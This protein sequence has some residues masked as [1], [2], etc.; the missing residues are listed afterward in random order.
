[1]TDDDRRIVVVGAGIGGLVL[2]RGLSK[3][4]SSVIVVEAAP[5]LRALG[6]G[7][8]L[9]ANAMRILDELELGPA[10]RERGRRIPGGAITDAS[11]RCLSETSLDDIEAR[12]GR[13]VAIERSLL[14]EALVSGI[15][16]SAGTPVEYRLGTSILGLEDAGDS[17]TV[18]LESGEQLKARAAIG[19]DGIRSRVRRLTFG[20]VEPTY[21]GYTCWRWTGEVP[22]GVSNV[23]EMWGAGA[24]AGLVP[25]DG[26]RAYAFFVENA[27]RGTPN[28][29]ERRRAGFVRKRFAHF[30]GEVPKVLAALGSDD[31][32]LLHHD[33]EEVILPSWTKERVTL[34]G[35]AAHALTPNLGQGAAMAIED[36][37]VLARELHAFDDARAA[38]RSYEARRRP[39]V[40]DIQKRSRSLGK[41][42]QWQ[43]PLGVW[44]RNLALAKA[45][46]SATRKTVERIVSYVP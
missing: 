10:V 44:L 18:T 37:L 15:T 13:A 21:S 23:V 42:A 3:L 20:A 39:R 33:I 29:P 40:E 27:E 5:A 2:A 6:A 16:A 9:G 1:M 25:L 28:D 24:R 35:D 45:P 8:T 7:I 26:Q 11:G 22:N 36:A 41:V 46:P 43:T 38:L 12:Y 32:E 19:A 4:G 31:A 14:H 30:S 34:L 17:V